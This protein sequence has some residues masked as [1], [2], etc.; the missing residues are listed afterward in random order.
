MACPLGH[1]LGLVNERWCPW[2]PLQ[3]R[4]PVGETLSILTQPGALC[5]LLLQLW[6]FLAR[7]AIGF[8]E[9]LQ[10]LRCRKLFAKS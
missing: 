8:Q 10:G 7:S 2:R 4:Q 9:T 3:I 5:T 6:F 1:M